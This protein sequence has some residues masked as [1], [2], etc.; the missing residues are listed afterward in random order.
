LNP[1][2]Q[3]HTD[4]LYC[5]P[6]TVDLALPDD[7]YTPAR[8]FQPSDLLSISKFIETKFLLPKGLAAFRCVAI[9]AAAMAVPKAAMNKYNFTTASEY[10][11]WRSGQIAGMKSVPVTHGV[12]H[13]A[14]SHLRTCIFAANLRHQ[15]AARLRC[16]VV[17]QVC[18][19]SRGRLNRLDRHQ[20]HRGE[21][22]GI[23]LRRCAN[24]DPAI[25]QTVPLLT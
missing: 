10:E 4:P 18:P 25:E 7:Q 11:V 16:K 21:I 8:I 23:R 20:I 19:R 1:P 6:G 3:K 14:Y 2:P 9:S 24:H 12:H 15:C 13:S 17:Y 5:R 22:S